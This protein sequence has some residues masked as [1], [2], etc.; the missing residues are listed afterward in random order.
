MVGSDTYKRNQL[1]WALWRLF[2]SEP[3][4]QDQPPA[5][6][7]N[8]IKRLLEIDRD[9]ERF[10]ESE[11]LTR[12]FVF[13]G[14]EPQGRG[15]E[16]RFSAFNVFT[17]ALA[18]DLLDTGFKQ[19]EIVFLLRHTL[20]RF[21]T[22]YRIIQRNPPDP[23][24]LIA[25]SDRPNA[26]VY[27]VNGI[28]CADCRVFVVLEKVELTETTPSAAKSRRNKMPILIEP[29][30]CRGIGELTTELDQMGPDFRKTVV[31]ELANLAVLVDEWLVKAPLVLRGRG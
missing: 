5:V 12:R 14:E 13:F 28:E 24:N 21:E 29:K 18:L 25:A 7:R 30:V 6:F 10:E 4:T 1:E 22:A 11:L 17:M 2:R 8:R 23:P 26:P 19:A 9:V 31:L 15:S 16:A 20:E 27:L 3:S